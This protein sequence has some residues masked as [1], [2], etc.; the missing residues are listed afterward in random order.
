MSKIFPLSL[1]SLLLLT[2]C[3]QT[4]S[5]QTAAQ[6][7]AVNVTVVTVNPETLPMIASLQGRVNAAQTAEVRP[8]VSGIIQQRQFTEGTWVNK[9]DLLYLIDPE[10]YQA[11]LDQA[12][13]NLV[14]AQ[15]AL[16]TAELRDQR[17]RK[18]VKANDVSR[19]DAEDAHAAYLQA[20]ASVEASQAAV[21]SA[22]INLKRTQVVAPISGYIGISSVTEGALV[23]SN[24]TTALTIIH[25]LDPIYVDLTESSKDLLTMKKAIASGQ[26]QQSDM[27]VSLTLEDGSEYAVKGQ[28]L[29]REVAVNRA[30]GSVTLRAQF[31]NPQQLLLP[32]MF[33]RARF[34]QA[35]IPNGIKVPQQG[36]AHDANGHAFALLVDSDNKVVRQPVK[37]GNAVASDWI[38]TSGLQAGDKVVIEGSLK[39]RP[40]QVV[41][42]HLA[43][44]ETV[45]AMGGQ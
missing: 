42:A 31:A 1:L 2:A 40:G 22:A 34:A 39:V 23:T 44:S 4:K 19:Q 18:L 33:V 14:T 21:N 13:A 41:T 26:L 11:A 9:G 45:T 43:G 36:I 12:K 30:T 28:L 37:L 3:D 5:P 16:T 15:A 10:S 25:S 27:Q 24:Q 6:A 8:Q 7:P 32:G 38:V 17:Y 35:I 20:Q 29:A